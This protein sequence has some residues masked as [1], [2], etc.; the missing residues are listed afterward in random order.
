MCTHSQI[1]DFNSKVD[2]LYDIPT[3]DNN[4]GKQIVLQNSYSAFF[5]GMLKWVRDT[6]DCKD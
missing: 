1:E 2:S 4:M 6:R 5:M 3:K